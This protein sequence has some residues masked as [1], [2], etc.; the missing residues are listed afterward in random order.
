MRILLFNVKETSGDLRSLF[1]CVIDS[2]VAQR[3]IES[4]TLSF[5]AL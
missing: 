2:H 1:G 5:L 3:R 4:L